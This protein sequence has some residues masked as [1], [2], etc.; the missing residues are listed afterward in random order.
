MIYSL[1]ALI[2]SKGK[3]SPEEF[4]ELLQRLEINLSFEECEIISEQNLTSLAD[5]IVLTQALIG[6]KPRIRSTLFM[7]L[8]NRLDFYHQ[9]YIKVQDLINNFYADRHPHVNQSRG[10]KH[11]ADAQFLNREFRKA[12]EVYNKI[13][14]FLVKEQVYG[15]DRIGPG[16]LSE[17]EFYQFCWFL[18]FENDSDTDFE[19]MFYDVFKLR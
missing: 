12:L 3:I 19:K 18:S 1:S 15:V 2:N 8:W 17:R 11:R 4:Q 14:G 9:G 10:F 7:K 13:K 6:R 5:L 16:K